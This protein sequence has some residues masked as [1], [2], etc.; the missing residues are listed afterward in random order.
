[1]NW[2]K[3][4]KDYLTFSKKDRI[5][6][7][8]LTICLLAVFFLPKM[9]RSSK[10][11]IYTPADTSWI[12]AAKRLEQ[13]NTETEA[14]EQYPNS[15]DYAAAYTYDRSSSSFSDYKKGALFYFNP[16]T[17]SK[18]GWQQLGL[19]DKTIQTIQNYLSKGGQFKKP[20]DLQK[21]YGLH[22]DQYERLAP[23]I[24]LENSL[25]NNTAKT[26]N[27]SNFTPDQ[28]RTNAYIRYSTVEI[29]TAD[30]NSFIALPGIGSKL[31]ARII[32]FREKLGGFSHVEQVKETYG[33]PDSTFQRIK[34]Y[35]Q[36]NTAVKKININTATVDQLKAHP[37]IR[38][39][40]ANPIIAY[41]NEHG[42][43]TRL[44]DIK[45]I[46]LITEE[47]FQKISPYISLK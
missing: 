27:E 47:V 15:S 14:A 4:S 45:K 36:V 19:R 25:E 6:I 22:R 24:Q 1:M 5:A 11:T 43:F 42:T 37:Y 3:I 33:L 41:R 2:A 26:Y 31:A 34:P 21:V 7:L 8:V 30:S 39:T 23:Y 16:N 28:K 35:L 29:N 13:K 38:Y 46:M 20:A 10:T 12:T 9:L 32:S 44:E 18:E 40:L 17:L